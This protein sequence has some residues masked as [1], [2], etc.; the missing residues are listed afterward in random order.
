MRSRDEKGCWWGL[1]EDESELIVI[2]V[3]QVLEK[4]SV[5]FGIE[6]SSSDSFISGSEIRG[7]LHWICTSSRVRVIVQSS[8]DK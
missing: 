4:H 1:W 2:L 7:H 6:G 3:G 8:A 5:V